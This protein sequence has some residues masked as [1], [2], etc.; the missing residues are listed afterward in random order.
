VVSLFSMN[1]FAVAKAG[2]FCFG[3]GSKNIPKGRANLWMQDRYFSQDPIR[4]HRLRG[5]RGRLPICFGSVGMSAVVL[6]IM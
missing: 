2:T 1:L 5:G 3:L 4:R 6:L